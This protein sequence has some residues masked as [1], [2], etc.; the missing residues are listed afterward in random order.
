MNTANNLTDPFWDR[1]HPL[2]KIET[3]FYET[4]NPENIEVNTVKEY[5]P[6]KD[7]RIQ[8]LAE[9]LLAIN[10]H[11][12]QDMALALAIMTEYN[13]RQLQKHFIKYKIL[14]DKLNETIIKETQPPQI[15]KINPP[16][17]KRVGNQ[18][19]RA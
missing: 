16:K 12:E 10:E 4:G 13:R 7:I 3:E 17:Y 8:N 5:L 6:E 9:A 14:K 15:P 18:I 11:R 19:V 1:N 2:R